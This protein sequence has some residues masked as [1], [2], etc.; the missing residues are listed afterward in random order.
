MERAGRRLSRS[1]S[2]RLRARSIKADNAR[3]DDLKVNGVIAW[4]QLDS[5]LPM[6]IDK[7][8]K[9]IALAVKASDV[10]SALN[11]QGLKVSGASGAGYSLKIDG[12]TVAELTKDQLSSGVNLAE[13]DTPMFR[14][15]KAV[16]ALTLRPQSA[17]FLA[18]GV[19][20][21]FPTSATVIRAW[22]RRSR[23]STLSKP[24]SS[25]SSAKR[26]S[27]FRIGLSLYPSR[28]AN[29]PSS[30][31]APGLIRDGPTAANGQ[32]TL[33]INLAQVTDAIG[34][35]SGNLTISW[36]RD[37]IAPVSEVVPLPLHESDPMFS[38]TV[39]ARDPGPGA[40][41]VAHYAIYVWDD[42]HRFKRWTTVAAAS[43]TAVF[44]GKPGHTYAFNSVAHDV[45]G[46]V[47]KIPERIEARSTVRRV[48]PARAR[49]AST[50]THAGSVPKH[51]E[52]SIVH[53][54]ARPRKATAPAG[55]LALAHRHVA[56]RAVA[57][58]LP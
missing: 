17:S 19:P 11:Q 16:H 38:A 45:A 46:N 18:R 6:P 52:P 55:P 13:L 15:A 56:S 50:R 25:P 3:V 41:G 48:I 24:T 32:Y 43:P 22:R 57:G 1:R 31:I 20:C 23:G 58:K 33:A 26:R 36:A 39:A 42:G 7:K 14:Q 10:E 5:A 8:D 37:A 49:K 2:T 21:R 27:R 34:P 12:E 54:A 44:T 28:D 47:E 9:A 53:V 51:K 40:L 35:G 4:T 30:Q 29:V